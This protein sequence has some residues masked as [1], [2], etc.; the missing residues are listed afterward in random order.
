MSG[1]L[2]FA[3]DARGV[4]RV[5]LNRPEAANTYDEELLDA[6][7]ERLLASGSDDTVRAIVIRG[8]GRHFC[9]GGDQRRHDRPYVRPA[10]TSAFHVCAVCACIRAA[11]QPV[12]AVVQ[13]ACLGGGLALASSCDI[14]IAADD[15]FFS[16]PEVRLGFV[17]D[18]ETALVFVRALGPRGFRRYGVAG[19]RFGVAEALAMGLAHEVCPSAELEGALER[20]LDDVLQAAPGAA[21]QVKRIADR[22]DAIPEIET[23]SAIEALCSGGRT[24]P[25]AAEGMAAFRDKRKP[26]WYPQ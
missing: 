10:G 11:R 5:T 19:Q 9:G 25:E 13:G 7:G 16:T 22:L 23:L 1:K 8:A 12:I 2:Q 18:R 17:P 21:S 4:A 15:A 3:L 20:Q 14:V 6:L 26:G 24:T